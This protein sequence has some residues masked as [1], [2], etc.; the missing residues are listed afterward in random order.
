[1]A[2]FPPEF[3]DELTARADLAQVVSRYTQLTNR[4]GRLWGLCPF[5]GEKTASFTVNP[6]KGLYYCF[7]CGKGGGVIQF[8]MDIERLDFPEAVAFLADM[9]NMELPQGENDRLADVRKRLLE[10][11]RLAARFFFDQ[12]ASRSAGEAIA[13]V[14]KRALTAATVRKFG[15]GYAPDSWNALTSYLKGKGFADH[16]LVEAGLA[17]KKENSV[18]DTFRHRLMFPIIDVRGN[19]VGF[20]GRVLTADVKGQK[21]LNTGNTPVFSKKNNLYAYQMAKKSG[22]DKILLVEGYMDVVSLHQAGFGFAVAS[23][24]TALTEDQARM[25]AKAA[26]QIIIAYD[27]DAAGTAATERAVKVLSQVTDKT[28]RILRVPGGKDPDEFIRTNGA[29][30]FARVLER[31]EEQMDYRLAALKA[32]A[33]LKNDEDRIEYIRKAAMLLSELGSKIEVEVYAGRVA[34]AAGV[35][36]DAVLAEV[37]S[38]RKKRVRAEQKKQ[39]AEDVGIERQLQPPRETGVRSE[40][41]AA[42]R[43]EEDLIALV[44]EKPALA[45]KAAAC[46]Q[47]SDFTSA[48]LAG[49]FEALVGAIRSEESFSVGQLNGVLADGMVRLLSRILAA[50]RPHMNPERELDD[51]C[52]VLTRRRLL[53]SGGG[54]GQDMLERMVKMKSKQRDGG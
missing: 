16:E 21:Y 44:A 32:G 24:G 14:R 22:S 9:Y 10:A 53:E 7:G 8:I 17:K 15:I 20:G 11:N 38:V 30:A 13:Y 2:H 6:E 47:P 12:L 43:A 37:A 4:G 31:S 50:D 34:E 29:E 36:R 41:P 45:E 25:L 40:N 42:A 23:L 19:V 39:H 1:M 54:D 52:A 5:H 35:S 51:L 28:V 3:L 26:D 18:Y 33:D 27:T 46:I 48:E 49:I